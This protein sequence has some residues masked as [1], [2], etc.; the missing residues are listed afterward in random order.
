[1]W[2]G[3]FSSHFVPITQLS[4]SGGTVTLTTATP[5]FRVEGNNVVVNNVQPF[6]YNGSF[7]V[8]HVLS[9]YQ[10][11][12]ALSSDPGGATGLGHI[13]VAFQAMSADGGTAAIAEGNRIFNT[14]VGGPYHDTYNTKDLIVRNNHYRNVV[15]GPYQALGAVSSTSDLITLVSLTNSGTIAIATTSQP[16]GFAVNDRVIIAGATGTDANYYNSPVEG[17]Q[18]TAVTSTTF[19]YQMG[20]TPSGAA[21]GSPGYATADAGIPRQRLLTSLSYA[22]ES[23]GYVATAQTSYAQ[24]GFAKGDAVFVSKATGQA[25]NEYFNGYHVIIG[26]PD[27]RTFKFALLDNPNPPA[28]SGSSPSGY[29]G[30]LWQTGRLMIENNVFELVPTP[31]NFGSP[32]A[33]ALD[34]GSFVSPPLFRQVVIRSNVIRHV[35]G[36]SDPVGMTP[37][38]GIQV[39]GCGELIVEE[40]VVDL[41][42]T[43]AI[44]YYLCDQVKFF[45]NQ[46]PSGTLV[47]GADVTDSQN[48]KKAKDLGTEIED[49]LLL[50]H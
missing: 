43:A 7:K 45:D 13:G 32:V 12:F 11:Q 47:Q 27:A 42:A 38:L 40:N 33:I 26:V 22:L 28:Q 6:G 20:G 1:M 36:A 9:P 17:V 31:T 44:Q 48:P 34:Y 25:H 39:S 5:H 10:L 14:R 41:D 18:I 21:Q 46:T 16:H 2:I 30:R 29:F 35:D 23:G 15:S 4:W 3:R 8:T 49:A 37:A 50:A 24:H 19:R